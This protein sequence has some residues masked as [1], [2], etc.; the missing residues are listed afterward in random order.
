[1]MSSMRGLAANPESA[2]YEGRILLRFVFTL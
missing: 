2:A 1:M